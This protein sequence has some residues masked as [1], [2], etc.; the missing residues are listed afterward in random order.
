MKDQ[1]PSETTNARTYISVFDM[2]EDTRHKCQTVLVGRKGSGAGVPE[3][4]IT[5]GEARRLIRDRS[6]PATTRDAVWAMLVRLVQADPKYWEPTVLWVA[7]THLRGIANRLYWTWKT[8]KSEIRSEVLLG[9]IETIRVADPDRPG[10]GT[11]LWWSTFRRAR[12]ACWRATREVASEH[13]ELIASQ[14]RSQ[15]DVAF[16]PTN[17][18]IDGSCRDRITVEGERL[19]SLA[20]RCGLRSLVDSHQSEGG[21]VIPFVPRRPRQCGQRP[22]RQGVREHDSRSGEAA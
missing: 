4:V 14:Q 19:G 18:D 21:A 5:A 22:A 16:A 1:L 12:E 20:T 15:E 6:T 8:D 2:I 9:F 11:H 13:A 7:L 3:K 17:S 10:I